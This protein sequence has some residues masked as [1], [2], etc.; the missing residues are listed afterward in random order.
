MI[1]HFLLHSS[2]TTGTEQQ[3]KSEPILKRLPL[4]G[5]RP[6]SSPPIRDSYSEDQ[7]QH[8]FKNKISP[9]SGGPVGYINPVM[10]S[11]SKDKQLKNVTVPDAS[12]CKFYDR[13][14]ST[15]DAA[16]C[17]SHMEWMSAK[18]GSESRLFSALSL[19]SLS[20]QGSLDT[21]PLMYKNRKLNR[22]GSQ[23]FPSL[24][25]IDNPVFLQDTKGHFVHVRVSGI[26]NTEITNSKA[27]EGT[28]NAGQ[29]EINRRRSQS[30]DLLVDLSV[31]D[32][33]LDSPKGKKCRLS[34]TP[35]VTRKSNNSTDLLD[36]KTTCAYSTQAS[37]SKAKSVPNM[38]DSVFK[39][40]QELNNTFDIP[41]AVEMEIELNRN[42]TVKERVIC[43]PAKSGTNIQVNAQDLKLEEIESICSND[44][45]E[46]PYNPFIS[47]LSS[48]NGKS[49]EYH[50]MLTVSGTPDV[51]GRS[52]LR[53]KW[54]AQQ[55]DV[56]LCLVD[57]TTS[58]FTED[59]NQAYENIVCRDVEQTLNEQTED[60]A[61]IKRNSYTNKL[62]KFM[63]K[64]PQT[65]NMELQ[66]MEGIQAVDYSNDQ[67]CSLV[68]FLEEKH[69]S[70]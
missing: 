5:P 56:D 26:K 57:K 42:V 53:A 24:T 16:T 7:P 23:S 34:T 18:T 13:T 63:V 31:S 33:E 17:E 12:F 2:A 51:I 35:S 37:K 62:R 66:R 41:G 36:E 50:E 11:S 65:D 49:F 59:R 20:S 39:S 70:F 8:A 61:Q 60:D 67:V 9:M 10:D 3:S 15:G 28:K 29:K 40:Q 48:P 44:S 69:S 54:T 21:L 22:R 52:V 27:S 38:V 1:P 64:S 58:A 14:V 43:S 6:H 25:G 55:S 45:A 30:F 68:L 47:N 4:V 19:P 32:E 46:M